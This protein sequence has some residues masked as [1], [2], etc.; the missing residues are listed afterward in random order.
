MRG[1]GQDRERVHFSGFHQA[2]F[3]L[4]HLLRGGWAAYVGHVKTA[5]CVDPSHEV[6]GIP[7]LKFAGFDDA[8][9]DAVPQCATLCIAAEGDL[10]AD[11]HGADLSLGAVVVELDVGVRDETDQILTV[12]VDAFL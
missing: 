4:S 6:D 10:A 12:L 2:I 7:I 11:H 9:D 8:V 3:A 5:G 1:A